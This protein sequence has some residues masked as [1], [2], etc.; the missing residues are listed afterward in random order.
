MTHW[1]SQPTIG[2]ALVRNL[3]CSASA[4][5]SG[6]TCEDLDFYA[7]ILDLEFIAHTKL[8]DFQDEFFNQP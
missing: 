1:E 4:L 6:Q 8:F 3:L 2:L 7:S 5:L